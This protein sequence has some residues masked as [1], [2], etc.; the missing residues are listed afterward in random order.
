MLPN[1]YAVRG[2][3]LTYDVLLR[4]AYSEN[5][6]SDTAAAFET[7]YIENKFRYGKELFSGYENKALYIIK[8]NQNL[9]FEV[10]E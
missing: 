4:L 2:F 8:Y 7:E 5:G 6:L 1:K 9:Q 10:V 3:D